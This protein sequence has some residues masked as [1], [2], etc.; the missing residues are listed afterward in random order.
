MFDTCLRVKKIM[1][2]YG[3]PWFFTGGWAIDLFL[4]NET[5]THDNLSIGVYRK[6][7]M[8]LYKYLEKPKKYYVDNTSLIGKL[9]KKEW[10]KEYLRLPIYEVDI[11]YEDLQLNIF[12]NEKEDDYWAYGRDSKIMR[13]EKNAI[14][15]TDKRI[16]FL[17][18]EIVCLY[19]SIDLRDKDI[20]DISNALEKMN[21]QQK[22]WLFENIE[23]VQL[24]EKI[25]NLTIAS[26]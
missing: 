16:P 25:R 3:F 4:G 6:N 24:R 9:I 5:R 20:K 10:N 13:E 18:P 17:C 22:A 1:D 23:N 21:V 15:Y 12:L 19:K 2:K 7:Q 26:T 8:K 14:L 11:K